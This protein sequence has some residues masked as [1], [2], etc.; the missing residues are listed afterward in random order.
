VSDAAPQLL[1]Q[2]PQW[3]G[4]VWVFWQVPAQQ[5]SLPPQ[6][7]PQ[8]PQCEVEVVVS[9]QVP[10]QQVRPAPQGPLAPHMHD[11]A[12]QLSP[13]AQ[14]GSQGMSVVH[15]PSMHT[16]APTQAL[17]QTPQFAS[18]A[19]TSMQLSSQHAS[20]APHAAPAPHMQVVVSASQVSPIAH[21]GSQG[22]ATQLPSSHTVPSSQAR[23]QDPQFIESTSR[24][25][26]PSGQQTW[27]G[28]HWAPP[29]QRHWPDWHSVPR[30][31]QTRPQAPQFMASVGSETQAPS[32]QLRPAMH[33]E[34]GPH[35][36]GTQTDP[37]HISPS[38]Q[39]IGHPPPPSLGGP[40]SPGV[41]PASVATSPAS[42]GEEPPSTG[43]PPPDAPPQ[44]ATDES[45]ATTNITRIQGE[46]TKSHRI[47][48][49][50]RSE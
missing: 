37:T 44:D 42:T 1:S 16:S 8:L 7:R 10:P 43:L 6:D 40:A 46:H 30:D 19:L 47:A 41:G 32:Q 12:T 29:A 39:V 48:P 33:G 9:T 23:P 20:P 17:P 27:S 38:G 36:V 11:P 31:P 24:S 25:V 35:A 49:S 5:D 50:T 13:A 4:L 45:S 3:S 15:V 2:R 18:S 22:G 14:A 28:G 21:G 34:S 26:H